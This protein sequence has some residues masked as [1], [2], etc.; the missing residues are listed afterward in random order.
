ML[1]VNLG[2]AGMQKNSKNL[3][4]F[5]DGNT[6]SYA[7]FQEYLDSFSLADNTGVGNGSTDFFRTKVLPIIYSRVADT[8]DACIGGLLAPSPVLPSP[9]RS[10][11]GGGVAARGKCANFEL[12]GYDF[13]I[14]EAFRPWLIEVKSRARWVL[15]STSMPL[16]SSFSVRVKTLPDFLV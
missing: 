13:M 6:R 12:F 14:D 1:M 9:Q 15:S 8:I 10:T 4:K 11:G 5:E 7:E 3:G 2:N 16:A